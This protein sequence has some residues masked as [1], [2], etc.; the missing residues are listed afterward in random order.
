MSRGAAHRLMGRLHGLGVAALDSLLPP[1]CAACMTPVASQGLLCARCFT[2]L[3]P[4]GRP[5]CEICGVPFLHPGDAA[6]QDASGHLLCAAC[7]RRPPPFKT[8]RAAFLYN[9]GSKRLILPFKHADRPE[10]AEVLAARMAIAGRQLLDEA[11]LVLPVPLHRSR[12]R[13]RRYNQAALLAA[14]LARQAGLPMIPGLLRRMRATPYLGTRGAAA[15]AE[16]LEDAFCVAPGGARL[17]AG[18][19][20]LLVDDVLTSGATAGA[21]ARTLLEAGASQVA[22][23]ASARVTKND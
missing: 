7:A 4:I 19:R 6:G 12:L 1:H 21:C 13:T 18:K 16:V 5:M 3:A 8:A 17:V 9:E 23:I 15:R 14:R 11:D 2:E 22:V 20:L 10:L